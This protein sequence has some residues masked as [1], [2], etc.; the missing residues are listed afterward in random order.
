MG[1]FVVV[2]FS[3][4]AGIFGVSAFLPVAVSKLFGEGFHD[5]VAS[6]YFSVLCDSLIFFNLWK[7][8]VF[9]YEKVTHGGADGFTAVRIHFLSNQLV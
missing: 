6:Q 3:A 1:F 7:L 9:I 4:G 2:A 5:F 8:P